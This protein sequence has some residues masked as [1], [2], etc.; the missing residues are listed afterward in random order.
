MNLKSKAQARE[1]EKE[2]KLKTPLKIDGTDTSVYI[3][4]A[5]GKKL[6]T[7]NP[8]LGDRDLDTAKEIVRIINQQ[9][10]EVTP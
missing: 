3:R 10:R 6:A 8:T 4:D 7:I 9:A 1:G 2:M 5:D